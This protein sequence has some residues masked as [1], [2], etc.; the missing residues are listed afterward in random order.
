VIPVSE[1]VL[2]VVIKHLKSSGYN[3]VL[4]ETREFTKVYVLKDNELVMIITVAPPGNIVPRV[5]ASSVVGGNGESC[6]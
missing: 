4:E 3:Y 5:F 1:E 6:E 2:E